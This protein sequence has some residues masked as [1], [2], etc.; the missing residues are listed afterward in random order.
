MQR[1]QDYLQSGEFAKAS[2]EF[3]NAMQIN[4]KDSQAR[5]KAAETAEKLG[6]LRGAYSLLQSV[7]DDHPDN[8]DARTALGRLLVMVGE[9]KQGL[10]IITPALAARPN[11][12][13]LLA[14]R[15][16]AK[17]A[18]Q[19]AAGARADAD[20]ALAA[21]SRNEDA[22]DLRAG[23]YREDG[24]LPA[25]IKLVSAAAAA[26][27]L[28]PGFHQVLISL[29]QAAGQPALAEGELR[30]LVKLKPD[31]LDYRAQLAL[32][33]SRTKRLD[34]AQKVLDDAVKALPGNDEAKLL[35]VD[36]MV[37]QRSH[38]AGEQALRQYVAAD[39]GD[40]TLRLA[41]GAL[42]Q[43][44]NDADRA[45]VVY[46]D[47]LKSAGTEANGLIARDRLAAI[48]IQQKR[49]TDA[50]RYL[51][52]VLKVSPRDNDALI[53]RG[54]LSLAHGDTSGAIADFRA[55]LRDQPRSAP[56]N[57]LLAQA[58]I[59]HGDTALAEE[60]LRT[61]VSAAPADGAL[62]ASLANVL[63]Q[64]QHR[65]Q[66]ITVL[67]E[68]IKE[69]PTD[70]GLN[71]ALIRAYLSQENLAAAAN[72]ADEYR[73][74]KPDDAA[75]YLLSGLVAHAQHRLDDAQSMLEK[76]LAI[77]PRGYDVLAELV[78]L[79]TERGQQAKAI[80]RL[81]ALIAAT[82]KD[83][84]IP[85]LLG[86]VYLQ[87]KDFRAAQQILQVAIANQPGWWMPYRNLALAR[88]GANDVPGAI[89]VYQNGLKVAPSESAMLVDLGALFQRAG[90]IDDALK[91]YESWFDQ[92]PKS[93]VAANNLAM[94]LVTYHTDKASLDR[95]QALTT[96]FASTTSGD[97][98]DTAGWVQFKRGDIGQAL[99]VLRRA[100]ELMPHSHE[101][102]YH[103]GMVELRSGQT[104]RA[105][106]DLEAA[107]AG[108][109]QFFGAEDARAALAS[110]KHQAG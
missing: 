96:G 72:A 40:Y 80:S 58:L 85:N 67:Q 109:P 84:L 76:S 49:E 92:N 30:A 38:D 1:G 54:E 97:L 25:A 98:V 53:L 94:V 59:S 27:P 29:Y 70:N 36:F 65:D 52:E 61:A 50:K 90:R 41:L 14:I 18:L 55:V 83:A 102:H 108:S 2:V 69:M 47:I 16:A 20:R 68:G 104:D 39:P 31:R 15:S 60:P 3:R 66:G 75:P 13:S 19:D 81:Q 4:P 101:V 62:R 71:E 35:R 106:S 46:S 91:L 6:Q 26:Q 23:L 7:V 24:N 9:P 87:Q 43:R 22:V 56:I 57:R 8:A 86:E 48:A 93:Q 63:F 12:A 64:L 28:V 105:R 21:D 88:L 10:N 11:D 77:Q 74:A 100:V 45:T 34:E 95:A 51:A 33:L 110:L 79:Q 107:L 44:L 73:R 5:L 78:R 32:F 42:L 82:P 89:E 99:P 37:Q 17:S 103:L